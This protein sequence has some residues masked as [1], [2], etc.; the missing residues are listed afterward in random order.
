[1]EQRNSVILTYSPVAGT[2]TGEVQATWDIVMGLTPVEPTYPGGSLIIAGT[3]V[4]GPSPG[5]PRYRLSFQTYADYTYEVY[6]NPTLGALTWAA[7]PFSLT[8]TGA[9][10]R[11]K[12]TVTTNGPLNLFL[13]AKATKGFYFV[14]FRVPGANT[15]TP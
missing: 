1:M 3:M 7:L 10:D 9:I 5:S 14:S 12:F 6:A 15:G 8:Q 2:T 11:H 13:D 4:P